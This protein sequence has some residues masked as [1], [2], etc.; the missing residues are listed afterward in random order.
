MALLDD[1]LPSFDQGRV[2]SDPTGVA[3]E[4]TAWASADAVRSLTAVGVRTLSPD[5][6]AGLVDA[7]LR[8]PWRASESLSAAVLD[9][10]LELVSAVPAFN[11]PVVEALV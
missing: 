8:L 7:V 5:V 4:I 3:R 2:L 11:K 9:F 6:H 10:A 1:A